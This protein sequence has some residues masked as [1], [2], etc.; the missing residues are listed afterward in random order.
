MQK[1]EQGTPEWF[2]IRLGKVTASKISDVL[3]T[4]KS[5]EAITRRNYRIQLVCER[6][7]GIKEDTFTNHHMER[8]T[9]LEPVARALYESEYSTFV[10]EIGFVEHPTIAM[11][12]ASPDGIVQGDE[13]LIEI[14]CPTASNHLDVV[15]LGEPPKKYYPQMQ[16]QLACM[17]DRQW[18]D[19]ISYCPDVGDDLA[20]FV[21]RVYRDDE[22][23]ASIETEV[24]GFLNEVD[25]L[26]EQLKGIKNGNSNHRIKG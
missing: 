17:P 18:V 5:G 6:L 3:A 7:T 16:W 23:I 11:S 25:I 1:I 13:G 12:G 10:D 15:L 8:G 26:M 24:M 20:L 21:K 9:L 2:A 19:F 14:K 4:V 22:Y